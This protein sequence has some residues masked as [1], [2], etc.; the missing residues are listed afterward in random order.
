LNPEIILTNFLSKVVSLGVKPSEQFVSYRTQVFWF[1][2][3]VLAQP[4]QA[5]APWTPGLEYT[6]QPGLAIIK[7]HNPDPANPSAY[8]QGYTGLGIRIGVIDT[9]INP[10]HVEF[11]GKIVAGMT[12]GSNPV[13]SGE[14]DFIGNLYDSN[15]DDNGEG[16]GTH[17]ASI[18]AARLDGDTS[19]P[20]NM[21][22]VAYNASLV[23]AGFAGDP[24]VSPPQPGI[25]PDLQWA[26]SFDYMVSQGVR[27]INN[28]WGDPDSGGAL[29]RQEA[30]A[31]RENAPLTVQAMR[32]A[33]AADV[34][35]VFATGND[36]EN[37][38]EGLDPGA[39]TAQPTYDPSIA[40]YGGWIAVTATTVQTS[41]SLEDR[42]AVYA[43]YCGVAAAYCVAAPGGDSRSGG[44]INGAKSGER[45][46]DNIYTDNVD[47]V[48]MDGTSM[49]TPMV[50]GA[51]ALVAEKYRWMT[52]RNLV[53]TI[54]TTASEA[55]NEPSLIYGRG[56]IDV[57]RAINGPAIFESTFEAN[58][59]AHS[60]SIFSNPISG[61]Y[62][63]QK[64]G[65][66]TLALT[67]TN[68]FAGPVEVHAGVL[69][70]NTDT[71]LGAE[72][73]KV[74]LFDGTLRLG[75]DFV[76]ASDGLWRKPIAVGADGAIIDT[77]GNNISYAGS[78]I[79]SVR[80]DGSLGTLSFVGTPM[81]I[82]ADLDLNAN[83]NAD[84]FI[85]SG[86]SL[87]GLGAIL[88][89]LTIDG[90]W[91]PGNSPGTVFSPGSAQMTS[92]AVLEIEVDG[93]GTSDGVGNYDRLVFTSADSQ[94]GANGTLQVLL[95]GISAPANNNY[96]PALG[97][98]FEFVLAPGGVS[99]SFTSLEQPMAGLLPGMQMDVVYR[100]NSLTLYVTPASYANLGAAGVSSNANREGL[101]Q[102]LQA[103][104]P[105]A[106]VRESD[107]IRKTLFDAL[108]PQTSASLPVSMDQLAG[109]SYVQLIGLAQQNTEFLLDQMSSAPSLNRWGQPGKRV[110]VTDQ[111]TDTDVWGMIVGRHSSLG[112]DSTIG[113]STD[114]LGGVVLG[115]EREI[116]DQAR[117]G[118]A[119]AYGA[120]SSQLP[121]N[122]GSGSTQN[123]QLMAY[124]SKNLDHG[125]FVQGGLGFGGNLISANRALSLMSSNYDATIKT[126]NIAANL[127]FGQFVQK[128][129]WN[130]EWQV[131]LSYLGMRTYGFTDSGGPEAFAV[132]GQATNNTSV[133]PAA[134][135]TLGIPFQVHEANWQFLA[136]IDYAYELADN[137]AYLNTVVL[138]EDLRLQSSDI[139]RSRLTVG[140]ALA[141]SISESSVFSLSINNQFASNWNG[142]SAVAKLSLW[143]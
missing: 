93:P 108:A 88:G 31:F 53:A 20:Q 97:Q 124:G 130:Y 35:I 32:R 113:T 73:G 128:A 65:Q 33:L 57:N 92:D 90:E 109:V 106:G 14:S 7:V 52:N 117:L 63:L 15:D 79:D 118:F 44:L 13:W 70:A 134:G 59:P 58:L 75:A 72:Q 67:A 123:L 38:G 100:P 119:M 105:A 23:I 41:G 5:Q 48:G 110:Q 19:R 98:G 18:A 115:T 139:G 103:I 91:Q 37:P 127:A 86:V 126:A 129:D 99:G 83:W 121:S 120:S 138:S 85:P 107:P 102:I 81:A 11:Q 116:S 80:G 131:G 2:A 54:L 62:G 136:S 77:N 10:S 84:L 46:Q 104:R 1:L 36:R 55:H 43:D 21:Q 45:N 4:V 27:V 135:L 28:S 133:Q 25:L 142:L 16:H 87:S 29:P 69:H 9:G 22:G 96:S 17:V 51:V 3:F 60:T 76:T 114:T 101:G 141:A 39:P 78:V 40:A 143:F 137:R 68:T 74:I 66:G 26:R 6:N 12:A 42:M 56:L 132:S 140:V 94:F 34:V 89:N 50:T 82:V 30:Q 49:A 112:G 125:Y 47:Y 71:S 122:M 8:D 64:T 61:D 111:K 24:D 95:R